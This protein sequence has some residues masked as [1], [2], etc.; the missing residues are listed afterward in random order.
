[1]T[2]NQ[3]EAAVKHDDKDDRGRINK[4]LDLA[5]EGPLEEGHVVF[6]FTGLEHPH[7]RDLSM[8]LTAR[9]LSAPTDNVWVRSLPSRTAHVLRIIR[10]DHLFR[11]Y[12]DVSGQTN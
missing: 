5:A 7:V 6:D 12:P 8:I 2:V 1:M 3:K 9:L 11:H 4:Q 10:L